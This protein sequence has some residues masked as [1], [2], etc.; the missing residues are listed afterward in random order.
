ML[1]QAVSISEPSML[2][3]VREY[4]KSHEANFPDI[5]QSNDEA[6]RNGGSGLNNSEHE[7]Q[8]M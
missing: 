4:T 3:S 6:D 5:N 2:I 7:Y 1:C 8:R